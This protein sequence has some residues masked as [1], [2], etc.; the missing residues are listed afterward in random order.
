M[1]GIVHLLFSFLAWSNPNLVVLWVSGDAKLVLNLDRNEL[2]LRRGNAVVQDFAQKSRF[3]DISAVPDF[4]IQAF[5]LKDSARAALV[6]V[7][8]TVWLVGRGLRLRTDF[9]LFADTIEFSGDSSIFDPLLNQTKLYE[10]E[11]LP[12]LISQMAEHHVLALLN[13]IYAE[14]NKWGRAKDARS[15]EMGITESFGK[16]PYMFGDGEMESIGERV[17]K[18]D[19]MALD[20]FTKL[21]EE[22]LV[23]L[24]R[25]PPESWDPVA[26]L[27]SNI[28]KV[29]PCKKAL[30]SGPTGKKPLLKAS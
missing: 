3:S 30:E 16:N 21:L 2:E 18:S 1:L 14:L 8:R 25:E 23:R 20:R 19:A 13:Q 26:Y 17:R 12:Y 15:L 6:K 22:A 4:E 7:D 27:L 28:Q 24:K 11:T 5:Y 29:A 9:S 10:I